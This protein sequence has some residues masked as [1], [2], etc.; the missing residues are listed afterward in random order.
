[1]KRY[2]CCFT[3]HRDIPHEK[4]QDITNRIEEAVIM[5]IKQGYLYFGAGGALGFD[6]L[7]AQ[8][9]IKLKKSYPQIKLILVLPCHTQANNW[10]DNDIAVYEDIKKQADKVRYTSND[11]YS[12]CM[13][14]RNCHLVDNS[15]ACI[16]YLAR[17]QGGTAYTVNYAIKN[18]L[19]IVN[20]NSS[21][22]IP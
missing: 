13:Y 18:G 8:T 5:L 9:V 10:S 16:C 22:K 21:K 11:Y 14:K 15:S 17:E 20:V 7:A 12:G 4:V 3:G 1:M 2:T 19:T 6:T